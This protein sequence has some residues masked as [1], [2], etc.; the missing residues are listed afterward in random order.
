LLFTVAGVILYMKSVSAFFAQDISLAGGIL[1]YALVAGVGMGG[2][3]LPALRIS[4]PPASPCSL[5]VAV[6]TVVLG[7]VVAWLRYYPHPRS[8]TAGFHSYSSACWSRKALP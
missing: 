7:A 4:V 2:Y 6:S 8:I 1:F 3:V 5:L